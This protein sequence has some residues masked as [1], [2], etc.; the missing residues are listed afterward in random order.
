MM[1]SIARDTPVAYDA[2]Q[3]MLLP[4]A[5]DRFESLAGSEALRGLLDHYFVVVEQCALGLVR[6]R[7]SAGEA[8]LALRWPELTVL[9]FGEPTFEDQPRRRAITLPIEGG[10][11]VATGSGARFAIAVTL[12]PEAL[13]ISVELRH[14]MPRAGQLAVVDWMYRHIQAR[15]HAWVGLRY[16]RQLTGARKTPAPRA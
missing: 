12:E 16:L 5:T 7:W 6:I 3:S 11:A 4:D 8:R 10:L 2:T 13:Q 15:V 14:Y 1:R 9:Q